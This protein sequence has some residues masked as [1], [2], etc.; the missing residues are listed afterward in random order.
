MK[1]QIKKIMSGVLLSG[2]IFGTVSA[3]ILPGAAFAETLSTETDADAV[4]SINTRVISEGRAVTED[5]Y[6]ELGQVIA[7]KNSVCKGEEVTVRAIGGSRASFSRRRFTI[8]KTSDGTDVTE[9]LLGERGYHNNDGETFRMPAYD[10]TI[11]SDSYEYYIHTPPVPYIPGTEAYPVYLEQTGG[12]SISV[13]ED[14]ALFDMG[15]DEN[16]SMHGY[17]AE[18]ETV[19]RV[20]AL[21]D[22]GWHFVKWQAYGYEL[23]VNITDDILLNQNRAETENGKTVTGSDFKMPYGGFRLKAVFEKDEETEILNAVQVKDSDD[24]ELDGILTVVSVRLPDG[25]VKKYDCFSEDYRSDPVGEGDVIVGRRL[26][27][28]VLWLK[29]YDTDAE[30]TIHFLKVPEGYV[31][32]GDIVFS[33]NA[34][35][36]KTELKASP[37]A[38]VEI[39]DTMGIRK[40]C[41]RKTGQD[42]GATGWM[43]DD[44]VL[45]DEY[46]QRYYV[47]RDGKRYTGWHFMTKNEGV[48]HPAW[49]YFGYGDR[50]WIYTGWNLMDAEE[51]EKTAHWSYFGGDGRIRT[52]WVQLGKGTSE[53]DGDSQ[54]H[55]S[56][57]GTNGWLRTGWVQLGKGTSDP[58]GGAQRHWSYF[59]TNGWL[60]TGWIELGKGTKEPDGGK[61]RHWS[62]FGANGWLRTGWKYLSDADGESTPHWSYFGPDG[63]LRTYWQELGIGTSNPDGNSPK[64]RSYFGSNGWM[65][66]GRQVIDGKIYYFADNGWLK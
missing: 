63:W 60:R 9:E 29:L 34:T 31:K 18:T 56:Y 49:M 30:Y 62:Y 15:A 38:S 59:G 42:L 5:E 64:H 32:P 51:G 27:D 7:D 61:Q 16:T 22:D 35:D 40:I 20:A 12:G 24:N 11:S 39:S 4:F 43:T 1:K 45:P 44:G 2:I 37:D 19:F 21:P 66:T 6:G 41:L 57:F 52:G 33:Y 23:G 28:K 55:W 50:G 58:D 10:I 8:T 46:S 47:G 25:S 54:R 48:D 17:G 53:L 26:P 13:V 3:G 36:K 65:R 14:G